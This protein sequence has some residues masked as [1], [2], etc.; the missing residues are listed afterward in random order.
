[1]LLSSNTHQTEILM[2]SCMNRSRNSTAQVNDR[3][4]NTSPCAHYFHTRGHFESAGC[5]VTKAQV[6]T[7]AIKSAMFNDFCKIPNLV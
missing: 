2:P 4:G 3:A 1:M 7:P 6:T 5:N